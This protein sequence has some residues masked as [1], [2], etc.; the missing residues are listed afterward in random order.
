[1]DGVDMLD[2]GFSEMLFEL[3]DSGVLKLGFCFF[4]GE[5]C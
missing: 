2:D 4:D 5:V 1:M 3:L